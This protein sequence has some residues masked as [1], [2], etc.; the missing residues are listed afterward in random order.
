MERLKLDVL[1]L[2]TKEIH[3]HLEISID[4]DVARHDV[5]VGT[6]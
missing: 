6:V 3:H 2:V 5:K 1:P 4:R